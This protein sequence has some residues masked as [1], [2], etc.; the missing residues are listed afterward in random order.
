MEWLSQISPR[1]SPED[2]VV[3]LALVLATVLQAIF[4]GITL[5]WLFHMRRLLCAGFACFL[6]AMAILLLQRVAIMAHHLSGW[7][8]GLDQVI[9]QPIV[10][11][12]FFLSLYFFK[13][14]VER[15]AARQPVPIKSL[16][17]AYEKLFY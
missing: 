11:V 14:R 12:L 8:T 3:V 13:V 10:S 1:G 2:G 7:T 17:E 16:R 6:S 5:F 9:L 4:T 15:Y